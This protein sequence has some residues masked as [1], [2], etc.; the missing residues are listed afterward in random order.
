MEKVIDWSGKLKC[1]HCL[2][3]E[4]EGQDDDDDADEQKDDEEESG[5][6]L[7]TFWLYACEGNNM[8]LI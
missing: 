6:L 1:F 4:D 5:E 8:R 3:E 7:L 2:D